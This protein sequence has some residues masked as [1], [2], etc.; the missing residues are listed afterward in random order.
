MP[1][2]AGKTAVVTGASSGIGAAIADR[3]EAAGAD[4]QRVSRRGPVALDVSDR[5][6]V[7]AFLERLDRL[8]ILVCAAGDNLPARYNTQTTLGAEVFPEPRQ[9]DVHIDLTL[10]R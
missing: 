3:L 7:T 4:V 5:A 10:T 6:A 1:E 8:D 2:L 9:G